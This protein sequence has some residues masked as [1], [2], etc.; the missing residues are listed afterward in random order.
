[1]KKN[2]VFVF[3]ENY[4]KAFKEFKIKLTSIS[5]LGYYDPERETML[6]LD[7]SD[8]ITANIFSQFN[9]ADE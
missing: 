4:K 7:V 8:N 2:I 3:N 6:E 9:P 5:I 1:M